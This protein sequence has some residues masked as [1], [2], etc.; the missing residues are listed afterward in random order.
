MTGVNGFSHMRPAGSMASRGM[1]FGGAAG[2]ISNKYS[3]LGNTG[4][5]KA[6]LSNAGRAASAQYQYEAGMQKT[7]E[8]AQQLTNT[9]QMWGINNFDAMMADTDGNGMISK[10]EYTNMEKQ[11]QQYAMQNLRTGSN[12]QTSSTGNVFGMLNSIT[13]TAGSVIGML[14]GGGDASSA[15]GEA[16]SDAA[17][18]SGGNW[19]DKAGD[20]IGGLFG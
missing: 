15:A 14:G 20:W 16:V 8:Y 9:A 19:L 11:L 1:Q 12:G 10:K 2:N 3:T 7:A 17:G 5:S 6:E 13:G 4:M 18:S